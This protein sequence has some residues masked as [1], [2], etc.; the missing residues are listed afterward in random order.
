MALGTSR[1]WKVENL[2]CVTTYEIVLNFKKLPQANWSFVKAS[3]M[4]LF[5]LNVEFC[6]IYTW[7]IAIGSG[8]DSA[9]H[10][11]QRSKTL[12]NDFD[13]SMPSQPELSSSPVFYWVFLCRHVFVVGARA[14]IAKPNIL[15]P[16][17]ATGRI[18]LISLPLIARSGIGIES[19]S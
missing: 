11:T 17:C 18:P 12:L 15:E 16:I 7:Q 10:S 3:L 19:V 4:Y 2:G 14:G 8:K 13:G 1:K 5:S 9:C 6:N